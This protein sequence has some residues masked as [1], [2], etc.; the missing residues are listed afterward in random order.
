MSNERVVLAYSDGLRHVLP[1]PWLKE[2]HG[3]DVVA[4][5]VDAGRVKNIPQV[6]ERAR[7]SGATV[8]I[9]AEEE[10]AEHH[11]LRATVPTR[12]SPLFEDKYSVVSLLSRPP[13]E[14]R[15]VKTLA[16]EFCATA[17]AH[18]CTGKGDD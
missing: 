9:N 10:F 13:I 14:Y 18:R 12:R 5:L 11:S 4:C 15:P 3:C 6:M 2:K 16:H 1:H 7:A 17:I 8:A